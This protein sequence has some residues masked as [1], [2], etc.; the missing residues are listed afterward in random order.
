MSVW[1]GVGLAGFGDDVAAPRRA[2]RERAVE[3]DERVAR[4]RDERGEAGEELE[5]GHDAELAAAVA[6]LLDAI[7]E[8][9]VG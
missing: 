8:L 5:R 9:A 6:Q 2:G 1:F 4:W 3:A 7:S